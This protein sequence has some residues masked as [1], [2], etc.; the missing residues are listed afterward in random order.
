M[1]HNK[2]ILPD[3]NRGEQ[4]KVWYRP[5]H[6]MIMATRRKLRT[7]I[8]NANLTLQQERDI[9]G[10]LDREVKRIH[11]DQTNTLSER[12]RY[13]EKRQM[14]DRTKAFKADQEEGRRRQ[15]KQY[16][17]PMLHNMI[18]QIPKNQRTDG[19]IADIYDKVTRNFVY[20]N[21]DVSSSHRF[22]SDLVGQ[23]YVPQLQMKERTRVQNEMAVNV[24]REES[25][26]AAR[27]Q[28]KAKYR[29]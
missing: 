28:M 22:I 11:F 25:L 1:N 14:S 29:Q 7:L 24:A 19:V 17:E 26:F 3:G 8:E 9:D 12:L 5:T 4:R 23:Q 13:W 21:C 27:E 20:G 2:L 10:L 6:E 18:N 16:V 15:F